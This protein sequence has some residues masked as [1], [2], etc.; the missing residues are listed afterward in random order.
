M[1]RVR[2]VDWLTA[3][4]KLLSGYGESALTLDRLCGAMHKTKGSFYHHFGDMNTYV[5]ALLEHWQQLQTK[6]PIDVAE[7]A[8]DPR[9][10]LDLLERTVMGLDHHLDQIIRAWARRDPRA[11]AALKAV[12]QTRLGYIRK[13]LEEDGIDAEQA[14]LMAELEYTTFLGAQ[15]RFEDLTSAEARSLVTTLRHAMAALLGR[16]NRPSTSG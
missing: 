3:G 10:R 9:A 16:G 12:D 15:Q 14:S 1:K 4:L 13:L 11:A 5:G 6:A 8:P 7:T 2:A